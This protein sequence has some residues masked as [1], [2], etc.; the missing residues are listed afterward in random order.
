MYKNIEH[1]HTSVLSIIG[2]RKSFPLLIFT[3]VPYSEF[4]VSRY[5]DRLTVRLV[6]TLLQNQSY[7][8]VYTRNS[9]FVCKYVIS[10]SLHYRLL[11]LAILQSKIRNLTRMRI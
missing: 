8:I 6:V 2:M 4:N 3:C 9:S 7:Y 10:T 5:I 11:I 1:Q